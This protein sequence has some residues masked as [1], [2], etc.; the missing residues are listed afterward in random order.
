MI[1]LTTGT[2]LPFVRLVST[3]DAWAARTGIQGF[4]QIGTSPYVPTTLRYAR[5]ISQADFEVRI[6]ACSCIISH[7]GMGTIISALTYGKPAILMPRRFALGEHRNDHQLATARK[8]SDRPYLRFI[9]EP[10]ELDSAY[11]DLVAG[12]PHGEPLPAHADAQFI[13]SL[14]ALIFDNGASSP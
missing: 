13:A 3:V 6:R 4:A 1:F 2:Q 11:R 10:H 14:R 8:L 5:F 7:A 9:Q 12:G